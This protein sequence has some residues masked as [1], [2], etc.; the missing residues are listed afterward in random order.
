MDAT[1]ASAEEESEVSIF[2]Q[3]PV[4]NAMGEEEVPSASKYGDKNEETPT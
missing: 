2:F 1:C 3:T 4:P